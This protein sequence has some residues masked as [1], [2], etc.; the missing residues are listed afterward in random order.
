MSK[1]CIH[2][3]SSHVDK[4]GSNEWTCYE[5]L[6]RWGRG[7]KRTQPE[8]SV[9][10]DVKPYSFIFPLPLRWASFTKEKAVN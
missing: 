2:C 3:K 7:K 4:T 10:R 9:C 8:H 6:S 5:C 1:K